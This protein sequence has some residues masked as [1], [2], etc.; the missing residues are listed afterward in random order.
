[1]NTAE[2]IYQLLQRIEDSIL[3]IQSQMGRITCSEDFVYSQEG[4]F[5]L[6]GICMQLIFIGES[7]K[8]I[9]AKDKS[10]LV[11]YPDI[12]WTAIMGLRDIIAHE[13][14]RID[15]EEI[16]AVV[17]NDLPLLLNQVRTMKTDLQGDLY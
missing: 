11:K 10:Y 2:R 1:M 16:Y 8:V 6:S 5:T 12:P 15:E 14:H 4:V 13:Y 3:L 17:T 7:V 9:D